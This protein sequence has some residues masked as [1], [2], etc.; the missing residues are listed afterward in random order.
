M[1][2]T[3][4]ALT[5]TIATMTLGCLTFPAAA[6]AQSSGEIACRAAIAKSV[7][8][9][10]GSAFK[11]T[12][13]CHRSRSKGKISP[14]I[15]C[16]DVATA[17]S[18]GKL[19]KQRSKVDS[20]IAGSSGP[21]AGQASLLASYARCP[22]PAADADDGGATDGIDSFA[23]LA[24]CLIGLSD[25]LVGRASLEVLGR[26]AGA[27]NPDT[28]KCQTTL[29]KAF[30][31]VVKTTGK[32]RSRCQRSRDQQGLGLSYGCAGKDER[33]KI[34][35]ARAKLGKLVGTRCALPDPVSRTNGNETLD[36]I[37]ACGDTPDQ[38]EQCVGDV[39]GARLGSG[40]IAMAYGLPA[41]CSA[42][43]LVRHAYAGFGT[44]LTATKLGAGWNGLAQSLDF[45]DE[46]DDPLLIDCDDDCANCSLSLDIG[47]DRPA[48][49]C[50]CANNASVPCDTLNGPDPDCGGL[51]NACQCFFGP[52]LQTVAA[53]NPACVPIKILGD[54]Q[55][56]VDLGT[57]QWNNPLQ[58][59]AVIH[60]G[61]DVSAPCPHCIGDVSSN[62]GI[63]DGA[64]SGG[65]RNNQP[66][67]TNGNHPTFG[68]VSIDCQPQALTNISGQGLALNFEL[69]SADQSLPFTLP[70][71]SP[72]GLCPCRVCA[73]DTS[74]G[75]RNDAECP[76]G[77]G[78]C[79][80]G[81]GAGVQ[82]NA[83][84]DRVCG[85]DFVC[86]AGPVDR[87]CD[88]VTHANGDG[89]F[90]CS[91]DLD[92]ALDGTGACTIEQP[93]ICYPDPIEVG[94][95]PGLFGAD[96]GGL[97]CIG[98]TTS[99]VINVASGLPGPVRVALNFDSDVG[100]GA[101]P[102]VPWDPP[103]GSNCTTIG[104]T[105]TTTLVPPLPCVTSLAPAC[106]GT[107][108]VGES[109]ASNG[110]VCQCEPDAPTNCGDQPFPVCG[111]GSCP[112]GSTCQLDLQGL[113]CTCTAGTACA[114]TS[115]PICG[116]DCPLGQSCQGN[117]L[118][119][120]CAC[121]P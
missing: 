46:F 105:T 65:A 102:S 3:R 51:N 103:I 44:Q 67:D 9:Y 74:I 8:K 49:V 50:R 37:G 15:D 109:C 61:L 7:G 92:C 93:R 27:L 81:G 97:A 94:G 41:S 98:V 23:E 17:D 113:A 16:N 87:F 11:V 96:V 116:G 4:T 55:G 106:G 69:L 21:C 70:C 20:V 99:A 26:P 79:S 40:L 111:S 91:S 12:Q 76:A 48:P 32:E 22:S 1:R 42:G 88:G 19:V 85:D 121:G 18:R 83:C 43:S 64:C 5:F 38:L 71:D 90:S 54:Y 10:V 80:G 58:V 45:S 68:P 89:V 57:G 107:C 112:A 47:T 35:K 14:A 95:H 114:D 101:D 86:H 104:S 117:L 34:A 118:G 62:D 52:P 28:A 82:P 2:D 77:V 66:C 25:G 30:S 78:P 60:L 119:V 75:C 29:G 84:T 108:P 115:F 110:V 33:G 6:T 31:R 39:V 36:K 73:G 120:A 63:R 56:T 53:G 59:A 100:C 72:G 13:A 24:D